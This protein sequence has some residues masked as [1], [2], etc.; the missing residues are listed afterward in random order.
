MRNGPRWFMSFCVPKSMN[1]IAFYPSPF[2]DGERDPPKIGWD[3]AGGV[4]LRGIASVFLVDDEETIREVG[5][6]VLKALGYQVMTAGDGEEA[7][8]LYQ[9]QWRGIDLV[10][11]DMVMPKMDGVEVYKCM[12]RINPLVKVLV[13]TGCGSGEKTTEIM[14]R[15]CNGYIQKPFGISELSVK[16]RNI[17]ETGTA[18]S[19]GGL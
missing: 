19:Q 13:I 15:G 14:D 11:L 1:S 10:L 18:A 4:A 6:E 16:I 17:C 9:R 2:D 3:T 5:R 8:R 7:V 12:K